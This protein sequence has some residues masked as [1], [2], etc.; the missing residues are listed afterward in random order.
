MKGDDTMRVTASTII[1]ASISFLAACV[2]SLNPFFTESDV[3]FDRSL[4]GTSAEGDERESWTFRADGEKEYVLTYTDEH[5]KA[6]VFQARLFKLDGKSFLDITPVKPTFRQDDF[7]GGHVLSLHTVYLI[8]MSGKTAQMSYLDP[9]WLKQIIAINP[10]AIGHAVIDDE[11]VLTDS[12]KNLQAFLAANVDKAS[13]FVKS[14]DLSRRE[15]R[16]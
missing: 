5:G 7:Y 13:A 1:L 9:S 16:K 10:K 14:T 11:I 8:T 3:Y 6:S 4:L 12:T 2:P 15:A